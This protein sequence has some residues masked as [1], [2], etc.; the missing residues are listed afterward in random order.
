MAHAQGPGVYWLFA[1]VTR[2]RGARTRVQD[3]RR[4][5]TSPLKRLVLTLLIMPIVDHQ[6]IHHGICNLFPHHS[7]QRDYPPRSNGHLQDICRCRIALRPTLASECRGL[8]D[9]GRATVVV[10]SRA[11][12]GTAGFAGLVKAKGRQCMFP[13]V[14]YLP[15][16]IAGS[17]AFRPSKSASFSH[18]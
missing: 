12:S 1:F 9:D 8:N 16:G 18:I 6:S 7:L 10:S 13:K 5:C 2:T 11:G 4:A 3:R 17:C 14:F 15:R